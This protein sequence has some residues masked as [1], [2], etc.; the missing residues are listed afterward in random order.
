MNKVRDPNR[1]E[2]YINRHFMRIKVEQLEIVIIGETFSGFDPQEEAVRVEVNFHRW[3]T[4]VMW[5]VCYNFSSMALA[6]L[7]NVVRLSTFHGISYSTE[8]VGWKII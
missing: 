7:R 8:V 5:M 6:E 1:E 3:N 2:G 4:D